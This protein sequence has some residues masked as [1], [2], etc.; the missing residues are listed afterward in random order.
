MIILPTIKKRKRMLQLLNDKKH[1]LPIF[2][3][4]FFL[5]F[6]FYPLAQSNGI[7]LFENLVSTE[8]MEVQG[9]ADQ[10]GVLSESSDPSE[11]KLWICQN[12]EDFQIYFIDLNEAPRFDLSKPLPSLTSKD[13]LIPP[14]QF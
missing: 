11:A 1:V 9:E 8:Q 5:L 10:N 14:P 12:L 13:I 4:F 3:W 2:N 6:S 7:E